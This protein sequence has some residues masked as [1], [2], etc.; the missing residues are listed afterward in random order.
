MRLTRALLALYVSVQ[1]AS[2]AHAQPPSTGEAM[3]SDW[4]SATTF[5]YYPG[6]HK[7]EVQVK[8]AALQAPDAKNMA[9]A[10][11]YRQRDDHALVQKTFSVADKEGTWL[12]DLP[13]MEDGTYELRVSLD[14]DPAR[15]TRKFFK[16][17]N[18][19]WL[20]NTLGKNDAIYPPFEPVHV[21][22]KDA[23]VVLRRYKMNGFGLWD[24]VTSEEK[25]IL[26]KPIVLRVQ[27][28]AG[29]QQWQFGDSR[30]TTIQP[31]L[32]VFEAEA[33]ARAVQVCTR[34]SL[35]YDGCMK[36]ELDLLPGKAGEIVQRLWLEIPLKDEESPLFHYAA[37]EAMRRNY[38]GKTPRGGK[39]TW[40]SQPYDKDPPPWPAGALPP[41]WKAEPGSDDGLIWTCRDIRPWKHVIQSDFVPYVWLGGGQ[42]GLAFFGANDKGYLLDPKGRVQT[43]ERQGD[44]LYLRVDLVNKPSVITEPRHIVFGLQASPTRPMP[45]NWQARHKI[46]PGNA[47][48]VVCWGGY[49]C[50][51]K[52][53]EG[54]HF[55]VV[56][57]I[58]KIRETGIVDHAIFQQMDKDRAEPWKRPWGGTGAPGFD[59]WL[60]RDFWWFVN[61]AKELHDHSDWRRIAAEGVY[62]ETTAK[63]LANPSWITYTE[64]HASD[65]T[66][67]EWEVFQDEW[68]SEWPWTKPRNEI[69]GRQQPVNNFGYGH[70]A[71]PDSYLDFC[72]YYH[73]EWFKRDVGVY[74]DN[75]MPYAMYNPLFSDAYHS[76]DGQIQP[77]C[78]IWQ[79]RAYYKR[80]WQLMNEIERKGVPHPLAFAQH[81]TNTLLLPWSTWNNINLDIEW[82]WFPD[83][84]DPAQ[85]RKRLNLPFPPDLLLAETTGRQT[86]SMGNSHFGILGNPNQAASFPPTYTRSEWGMRAVHEIGVRS[87]NIFERALWRFGYGTDRTTVTNYWSDDPPV[88]VTDPDN[89]KWLL[90]TRES[91]Q[92]LLL[93]VQTW[94]KA[95]TDVTVTLDP[96][97]LGFHPAAKAWDVETGKEVPTAGKTLQLTLPGPYGTRVVA[98]LSAR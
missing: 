36:V 40:M 19:V 2:A 51:N 54:Y 13:A 33:T 34:S 58:C 39:I 31:H 10:S 1:L 77:A 68:R 87:N 47:G 75:T 26:A 79:Q 76:E 94:N 17:K 92:A 14:S 84:T 63:I 4:A 59:T 72:L 35:E 8:G 98:I 49:L 23:G 50:A 53:P 86:G 64:E 66:E 37:F 90:V 80:V 95:G 62:S 71:F 3:N 48:P 45:R 56:D 21:K 44:I 24:S 46:T 16:H 42:R 93:V 41:V 74:F 7:L 89:N 60:D 82:D 69:V 25:E 96:S 83:T 43:I 11:V 97:R 29:E 88:A 70:Q 73:N 81:I 65:V 28:E 67:P 30:W 5:A 91:D 57:E 18:F 12:V 9:T 78:S 15:T 85:G 38:A 22:G 55:N 6:L 27:T 52:Y 20:G 32:A 61:Q